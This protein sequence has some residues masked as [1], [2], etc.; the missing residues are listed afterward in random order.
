MNVQRIK[1]AE[2]L[3][4]FRNRFREE[5]L[6][7]ANFAPRQGRPRKTALGDERAQM[8]RMVAARLVNAMVSQMEK[9]GVV[10]EPTA[11]F[12]YD[13]TKRAEWAADQINQMSSTDREATDED[14]FRLVE[15]MCGEFIT[16]STC[17]GPNRRPMPVRIATAAATPAELR[18]FADRQWTKGRREN[19]L[20]E[21]FAKAL[22]KVADQMAEG[23]R[24]EDAKARHYDAIRRGEAA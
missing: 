18:I 14:P 17:K 5:A 20:S 21:R 3:V 2:T 19:K 9:G 13:Q 15:K 22:S 7:L 24:F 4:G 1:S 23:E 12:L 16:I 11:H 10:F 8:T 6:I